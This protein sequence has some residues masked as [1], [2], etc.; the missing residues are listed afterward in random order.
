MD[1][2]VRGGRRERFFCRTRDI[3]STI[4]YASRG[5]TRHAKATQYLAENFLARQF[6]SE[7]PNEQWLTDVTEF[8]WYEGMV[9][10]KIY[11]SAI[12][13]LYDYAVGEHNDNP[14]VFKTFDRALKATPNAHPRFHS[15][16]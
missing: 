6:S 1:C 3:K 7:R 2:T 8:K 14:L 13:G 9:V 11:L 4:E 5:C 10:H 16:R 15:D 12:L